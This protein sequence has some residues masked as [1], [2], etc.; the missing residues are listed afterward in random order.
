MK[1]TMI[2]FENQLKI[3][4]NVSGNVADFRKRFL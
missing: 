2:Y 4:G 3:T 1:D